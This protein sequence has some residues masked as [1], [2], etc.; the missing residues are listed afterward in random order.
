M[1]YFLGLDIGTGGSRALLVDEE[2]RVRHAFT[3]PHEDTR[4][5]RP[6]AAPGADPTDWFNYGFDEES[7]RSA[8]RRQGR[9]EHARMCSCSSLVCARVASFA[10]RIHR[11]RR[12]YPA[13]I[14]SVAPS[15]P[16]AAR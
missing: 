6:W 3:A 7:A 8:A 1:S 14:A 9:E 12:S 10:R 16:S 2:G 5:E 4:M 11:D 13:S 15:N